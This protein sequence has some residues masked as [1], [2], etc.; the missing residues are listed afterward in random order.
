[1]L[2]KLLRSFVRCLFRLLTRLEAYGL[3]NIPVQ[4]GA[5]LAANHLSRLDSPFIFIFVERPDVTGLVA[6]KYKR[7]P[8]FAFL[9]R[10]VNGIWINRESADAQALREAIDYLQS[11]GL[12]GIA[13]EGTRSRDGTLQRAKTGVAYLADKARVPVIPVAIYGT[14]KTFRELA[15]LRKPRLVIRFGEPIHLPPL[16]S[17]NRSQGLRANTDE[18]ICRIA[19]ML[20]LEYRGYYAEH[21]LLEK[22]I[23]GE[24]E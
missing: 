12:L 1:M 14:E 18:I 23:K 21:P 10:L 5:I 8:F 13:P 2:R 22:H 9:V 24:F 17:K 16:D 3:E 4:G 15:R 6:N 7:N 11:G 19:A 20:P